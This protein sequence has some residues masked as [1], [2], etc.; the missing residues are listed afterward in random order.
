MPYQK[1]KEGRLV[2][3]ITLGDGYPLSN[4]K[5]PLK[6]GGEASIINVSSPTPD[7]SVDGEVEVK[8]KLRAKD[9]IIQGNLKAFTDDD[10][11]P[12]FV[13]ESTQ[14]ANNRFDVKA[15]TNTR[16]AIRIF[17]NQGYFEL[18][19]DSSTTSLQFT[20]GT[21]TPLTL[22][23]NTA[24]FAGDVTVDTDTLHVDSTNNRVGIGTTSPNHL[25][26]VGDDATATFVTNPDKAIQL[27]STTND[28]EIAYILYSAE[29]TNN[30]RSKY[31]IDDDI[32]WVGWDSTFSTGLFGYK[33]QIAGNDKMA[34]TTAGNLGIGTTSPNAALEVKTTGD[35][36]C[37]LSTDGDAGD[38]AHLQLYRN[39]AAYAQFHYEADGGT[40]AGLHLTDFRDSEN[41][42]I[43]FNTRGDNERMRIE[44]DGKVGIGL[45]APTTTLDVEG[46]VSYKH[47]AFT[48]AGPTDNV[49]VSDTTVLEV[50]T[51][52]GSVTIGGFTGGV[53]GQIL[54]VVKTTSDTYTLKLENNEGGGSQDIFSSDNADISL[55]RIRG[56]V[57]LY[58]NGTSWFVLNK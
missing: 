7:N 36:L 2:N 9:T 10:T 42:H 39:S 14:G 38:V 34:L 15:A 32:Q 8:G 57:T 11:T 48:T 43:I 3:E 6:V 20:D 35:T 4:D 51:S 28:E 31:F 46:T 58:C 49:D 53:Q 55:V 21:N 33:W 26:H 22:D 37:R 56:G 40:N 50:D 23:G 54:Y 12:Q 5:Q 47:I 30:I 52:G 25:L 24:T 44:S 13:F 45:T 16:S 18:R 17:N 27:S 19:R 1:T 29:G 41:A